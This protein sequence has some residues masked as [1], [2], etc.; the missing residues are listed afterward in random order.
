LGITDGQV[1]KILSGYLK[2]GQPVIIGPAAPPG[3]AP[4]ATSS[5][6]KF[7]LRR[8]VA[9]MA[10]IETEALRHSYRDGA[11]LVWAVDG[12]DLAIER[13]EVVAVTGPSG[14]AKATFL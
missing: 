8:G 13:G 14:S 6:L 10:L 7:R 11:A 2:D 9:T 5:L 3:S 12:I 1:T 4:D